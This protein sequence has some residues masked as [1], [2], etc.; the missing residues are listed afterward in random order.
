MYLDSLNAIRAKLAAEIPE[1]KTV[2]VDAV[3]VG[4]DQPSFYVEMLPGR[5]D[6]L[7]RNMVQAE[8]SWQVVYFPKLKKA[9]YPDRMDQ[10]AVMDRLRQ[11]FTAQPYLVGPAGTVFHIMEFDGGPRDDEVYVNIKLQAQYNRIQPT[12]ETIQNIEVKEG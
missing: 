11:A 1:V 8:L 5:M 7:N 9:G 4:F 2:Y 12:Y 6:D 3:P 10:L